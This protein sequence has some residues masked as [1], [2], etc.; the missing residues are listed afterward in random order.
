MKLLS[1]LCYFRGFCLLLRTKFYSPVQTNETV[2]ERCSGKLHQFELTCCS[3]T[4]AGRQCHL[5]PRLSSG[6]CLVLESNARNQCDLA[7][8]TLWTASLLFPLSL[9]LNHTSPY[10]PFL[11]N[12]LTSFF[13]HHFIITTNATAVVAS[14]RCRFQIVSFVNLWSEVGLRETQNTKNC[15]A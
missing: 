10:C 12:T 6:R 14:S 7:P 15:A 4:Q 5:Q 13:V 2:A 11:S 8:T 3:S 9:L 1:F